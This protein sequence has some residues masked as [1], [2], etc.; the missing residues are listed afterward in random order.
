[1]PFVIE[2]KT[3]RR[4]F[5]PGLP[6]PGLP[7]T[8]TSMTPSASAADALFPVVQNSGDRPS[9]PS[10]EAARVAAERI[11]SKSAYSASTVPAGVNGS[12]GA[13]TIP[14]ARPAPTTVFNSNDAPSSSEAEER[15]ADAK[16]RTGR[17]LES[18]MAKD[19][20]EEL[21]RQKEEELAVR[22][23]GARTATERSTGS[24]EAADDHER[25]DRIAIEK[26]AAAFA[27]SSAVTPV[28]STKSKPTLR[29]GQVSVDPSSTSADETRA[30]SEPQPKKRRVPE[31]RPRRQKARRPV[32]SRPGVKRRAAKTVTAKSRPKRATSRRRVA[33]A[34]VAKPARV[35]KAAP[36]R[37]SKV[38]ARRSAA[39]NA[40]AKKRSVRKAPARASSHRP[41]TGR[42]PVVAKKGLKKGLKSVASRKAV[43]RKPS[44]VRRVRR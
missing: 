23:R 16:P 7:D 18:L 22:R 1:M 9:E 27:K 4:R 32:A 37:A 10:A 8:N 33:S 15:S 31:R 26:A 12:N 13:P 2:F 41:A 30:P 36:K 43:R 35:R 39:R 34:V 14:H 44:A 21:L 42:K 3:S 29:Q 6:K 19:P 11:F 28:D 17:I 40:A 24:D 20:M 5:A 25:R 38:V